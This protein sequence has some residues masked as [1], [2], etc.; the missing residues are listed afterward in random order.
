MKKLIFIFLLCATCVATP[1]FAGWFGPDFLHEDGIKDAS[2][3]LVWVKI[4]RHRPAG[5]GNGDNVFKTAVWEKGRNYQRFMTY[6]VPFSDDGYDGGAV[7]GI[8]FYCKER[9]GVMMGKGK[10][11]G[12]SR[13][14]CMSSD[15]LL[16]AAFFSKGPRIAINGVT[17]G[18]GTFAVINLI[19][20]LEVGKSYNDPMEEFHYA[21]VTVPENYHNRGEIRIDSM[22]YG[23]SKR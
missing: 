4:S 21:T 12:V 19:E 8:E 13:F 11:W 16:F 2:L 10:T 17:A 5:I 22:E 9:G 6:Y 20:P 1:A 23:S 14:D 3:K 18:G 7:E 15:N